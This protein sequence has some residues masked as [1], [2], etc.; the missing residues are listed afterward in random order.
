MEERRLVAA[1][2]WNLEEDAHCFD[3]EFSLSD[4]VSKDGEDGARLRAASNREIF[5]TLR[6]LMKEDNMPGQ[7][8]GGGCETR[9]RR[10]TGRRVDGRHLGELAE[11]ETDWMRVAVLLR[12]LHHHPSSSLG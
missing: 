3:R 4:W 8:E 7:Q 5:L 9:G 2:A 1:G 12:S 11:D 10:K 6:R